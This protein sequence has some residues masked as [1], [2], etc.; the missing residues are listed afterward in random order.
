MTKWCGIK[1]SMKS[2]KYQVIVPMLS[3]FIADDMMI[4]NNDVSGK[5]LTKWLTDVEEAKN[6]CREFNALYAKYN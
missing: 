2:G 6:A 4:N 3:D 5:S 1:K